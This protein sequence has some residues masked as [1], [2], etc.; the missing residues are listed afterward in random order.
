GPSCDIYSLGVILYELLCGELPFEGPVMAMLSQILTEEPVP[1]GRRRPSVDPRLEAICL[2]AMA[3]KPE[4][5]FASMAEFAA[6]LTE[7]LPQLSAAARAGGMVP[8]ALPGDS[9]LTP[10][11]PVTTGAGR[12]PP[13]PGQPS[14]TLP[15]QAPTPS[16]GL[17]VTELQPGADEPPPLPG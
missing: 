5:R 14:A 10:A 15:A 7:Y 9:A 13:P 12:V 3:K 11:G 4:H 1:P 17:I 16:D 6:A 2:K 8:P